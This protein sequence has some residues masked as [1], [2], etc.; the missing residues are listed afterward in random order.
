MVAIFMAPISAGIRIDKN[1]NLSL[2]IETKKAEAEN[3]H[4]LLKESSIEW[5]NSSQT[6]AQ[7]TI[8]IKTGT[9][10]YDKENDE[11][12]PEWNFIE[13]LD[14]G[15][16]SPTIE[17]NP[18]AIKNAVILAIFDGEKNIKQIYDI[19]Q[20]LASKTVGV[21]SIWRLGAY[22]WFP[23]KSLNIQN[24]IVGDLS[25]GMNY[26]A[27]LY[28]KSTDGTGDTSILNGGKYWNFGKTKTLSFR[29][30][31]ENEGQIGNTEAGNEKG[32]ETTSQAGYFDIDCGVTNI[33]GC[34]AQFLFSIWEASAVIARFAGQF[35]DF[36]IYYAT[37]SSSYSNLFVEKAW[38]AV[39]D[40]A[41]ILFIIALFYVAIKT[42]L[43]LNVSNNKKLVGMVIAMGLVINFSL[44]TTKLVIDGSNILAK[45]FYNNITS[46][47][48]G[49]NEVAIE[50]NGQKSISIGIIDKFNP[51]GILTPETYTMITANGMGTFIFL[52]LFLI[53]ITLYTAY[54]F[55]SVAFLFV[56]RVV[57]LWIAMIFSP[58]AFASYAVP[59]DIP[60]FGHKEWWDN[61]S[62]NAMLAPIFIFF[63]YII[64]LF[65]GFL[66]DI[67][68]YE[69][70]GN[71]TSLANL[72][73]H[74][75][76]VAI[77]FIIIAILLMKSK[78]FAEKF[79]GEIGK[80]IKGIGGALTGLAVGGGA[81]TAAFAGRT[82]FG[83]TSAAASRS[84]SAEAYKNRATLGRDLTIKEKT[85]GK[86]GNYIN[87][88]QESVGHVDHARHE[89]DE[90][91][92]KAGLK[93]VNDKFLSK[94]QQEKLQDTFSKEKRSEI[95]SD[96]KRGK[97]L[98]G[99][100]ITEAMGG[101]N[102]YRKD[103]R[104]AVSQ[105]II[106]HPEE[107]DLEEK[108]IKRKRTITNS[109]GEKEEIEE[110][111]GTGKMILSDQGKKKV[112]DELSRKFEEI[113]E[114]LRKK[115]AKERFEHIKGEAEKNVN[116]GKRLMSKS[117][118]GSYDIRNFTTKMHENDTKGL[119]GLS[120]KALAGL[121]GAVALGI[122][123]G[124]KIGKAGLGTSSFGT[125]QKEFFKDI[126]NTITESLKGIKIDVKLGA[127]GGGGHDSHAKS[128]DHG[129]HGGGGH[130]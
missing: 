3:I 52:T 31:N 20:T 51:Q 26:T 8:D 80:S 128:D 13:L 88:T 114:T 92:E 53:A 89:M 29:T 56:A 23:P 105:N 14:V 102:Q 9:N 86:F 119:A 76:S 30:S 95:E 72:M 87:K 22:S 116:V 99:E 129:G 90:L 79:A 32:T 42:I 113:T 121:T 101:I 96:I 81:L 82:A 54:I 49:T 91:K 126:G 83:R 55:F 16:F 28:Y 124:M 123:S 110:E 58:I 44:F 39:R 122:R 17:K 93:G 5:I 100:E 25:A 12:Y 38:A 1:K 43:G 74:V 37:N 27:G 6:T 109:S 118:S 35:L 63:L 68:S 10:V 127:G 108:T 78:E 60:G 107:G 125:P 94:Q 50:N 2:N 98:K 19:S 57:S 18:A 117:T 65:T 73:Q 47:Y 11:S 77:P 24:I 34:V 59:F 69:D 115:L 40:I 61:L 15:F 130:H 120:N 104:Q 7:F 85:W 46:K 4:P 67:V 62:K 84:D 33:G 111:V 97:N 112:E 41:N 45:V 48:K 64:I 66:G 70:N 75:M 71:L 103:N 106:D 36:F 21:S